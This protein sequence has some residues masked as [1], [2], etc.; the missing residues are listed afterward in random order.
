MPI[1]WCDGRATAFAYGWALSRPVRK[2]FYNLTVTT[3]SVVIALG[4]GTVELLSVAAERLGL[5]GGPWAAASRI[6]LNLMGYVVVG[7]FAATWALAALAWRAGRVEER[8]ALVDGSC[9]PRTP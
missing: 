5:A 8:W 9:G 1:S 6:D 4:I 7:L 2:L 3:L